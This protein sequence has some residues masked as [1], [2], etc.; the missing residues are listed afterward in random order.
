MPAASDPPGASGDTADGH[1][2][3]QAWSVFC[4]WA[5]DELGLVLKTEGPAYLLEAPPAADDPETPPPLRRSWFRRRGA[6]AAP[7]E[8]ALP[9]P[10]LVTTDAH[11]LVDELLRRLRERGEVTHARPERQPE[12]VH[13]LSAR[14][15]D[16]YELDGEGRAHLAGFHLDD[17]PLVLLVS[18][19]GDATPEVRLRYYDELGAPLP[20]DEATPLGLDR[21]APIGDA[22]PRLD[23]GRRDRMLESAHRAA[24][25]AGV[26]PIDLA[27]IVWAKRA[28]GRIRFDFGD[29]SVDAEFDGWARTLRAPKVVCPLTGVET[30]HLAT[31]HGGK[32]AAAD[33]IAVCA[34]TGHRRVRSDLEACAATGEL[35][36]PDALVECPV[37]LQRVLPS[38]IDRCRLCEQRVS[39]PAC[40]DNVCRACREKSRVGADDERIVRLLQEHPGL[41][42]WGHWRLS[43]TRDVLIVEASRRLRNV[44]LVLRRDTLEPVRA[45]A[46]LRVASSWR[47][48]SPEQQQRLLR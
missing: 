23:N 36:E 43:Q 44:L 14:L 9:E 27:A 17:T 15:F 5:A 19:L 3:V 39:R 6:E 12:A 4:A 1:A 22:A 7:G 38:Q 25:E 41:A 34:V 21:L 26:A 40:P 29:Q 31:V 32:I 28:W 30:Y 2:G 46:S 18:V 35:A 37:T 13:E 16:A 45:M 33:Q 8:E 20:W 24:R 42:G 47:P 48:L 11:R 10:P